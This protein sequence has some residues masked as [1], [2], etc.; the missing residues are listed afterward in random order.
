MSDAEL[1]ADVEEL[2]AAAQLPKRQGGLGP[3]QRPHATKE[4]IRRCIVAARETAVAC[5]ASGRGAVY[6]DAVK[7]AE[8]AERTYSG[9][10]TFV[11]LAVVSAVIQWAVKRWLDSRFAD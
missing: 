11:T 5:K 4:R 6:T 7:A 10:L 1:D 2:F 3:L 8:N 9:V